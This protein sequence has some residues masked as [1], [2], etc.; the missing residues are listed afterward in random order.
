[1]SLLHILVVLLS[2]HLTLSADGCVGSQYGKGGASVKCGTECTGDGGSCTCGEGTKSFDYLDNTT[3]CCGGS[4]CT[5]HGRDITCKVGT[6]LPLSSPCHGE[7]NNHRSYWAGRQYWACDNKEQCSK[8]QHLTDGVNHCKDRSDERKRPE[9]VLSP[10]QW[11]IINTCEDG[12]GDEGLACSGQGLDNDCL[13]YSQWCNDAFVFKC[14]ELG[15]FRTTVHSDLCSNNTFWTEKPCPGPDDGRRCSSEKSG[16]CYYPD[17]SGP[18]SY[19]KKTCKDG[20]HDILSL[21]KN[22][23]CPPNYFRCP[24]NKKESCIAPILRCD[25]QEKT[26]RA[27]S[28][29]TG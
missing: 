21:P 18:V 10:I 17:Y 15:G 23:S 7:C 8:I 4:D 29:S 13:L 16:Q 6:P 5:R 9:D 22:G 20:S 27:V 25:I 3:W 28:L 12:N 26:R 2:L 14:G 1:M 11:D 19:V 24:V